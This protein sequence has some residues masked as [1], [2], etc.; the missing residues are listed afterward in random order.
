MYAA[1]LTVD[2]GEVWKR[3]AEDKAAL[4]EEGLAF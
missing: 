3:E 1:G 4:L 2:Q